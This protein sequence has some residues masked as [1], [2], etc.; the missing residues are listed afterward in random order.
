MMTAEHQYAYRLSDLLA[1]IAPTQPNLDCTISGLSLDSR[2]VQSGDCFIALGGANCHGAEFARAAVSAGASAVLVEDVEIA[3]GG[4]IPVLRINALRKELG[5]I[6]SRFYGDPSKSI[7][8][9]AVTGTN[10]KTTVAQLCANA[11]KRLRGSAAYAGTLGLGLIDNLQ[12]TA[13]T[14]PDPLTLQKLFSDLRDAKCSSLALEVSSH[15]IAQSRVLGTAIDV[16]VFT[17]LGHDHLDYHATRAEYA[18]V[19]KALF[20]YEGIKHAVINIDDEVGLALTRELPNDVSCWTFSSEQAVAPATSFNHVYLVRFTQH[21]AGASLLISTPAGEVEITTPLIGSFNAQNLMAALAALMALGIGAGAAGAALGQAPGVSGRMQVVAAGGDDGP[22]VVVDY[23]H[24]PE[25]LAHAL[26]GL[27]PMTS[28]RII[29]VFGCGGNRDKTKRGPMGAIA[30]RDAE[31]IIV[32]SDNPRSEANQQIT[33][34]ILEG[35]RAPHQVRVIHDRA[36][37]IDAAIAL[38][39]PGDTVLIAGKGHEAFQD[40]GDDRYPFS[41]IEIAAR[42]IRGKRA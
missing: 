42:S 16:A 9:I 6:A 5:R 12:P 8:V 31:L 3:L 7:D 18:R 39:E 25:S 35:M 36:R 19:K 34:E 29:C 22:L 13:N 15:A 21:R 2:H 1:G 24:T 27:R 38:A 40:V 4:R 30:E 41:D 26:A 20:Q 28:Q 23:A 33:D 14:T 10:G 32:T 11:L 37:A 17:N